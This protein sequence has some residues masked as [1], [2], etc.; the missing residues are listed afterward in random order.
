M[1]DLR[2]EF[3]SKFF[4]LK[5]NRKAVD[6]IF[7]EILLSKFNWRKS[8]NLEPPLK[9]GKVL[10]FLSFSNNVLKES[11]CLFKLIWNSN[12]SKTLTDITDY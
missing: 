6:L 7:W 10:V 8:S 4:S 2:Q 3:L 1:A 9:M 11:C 12:T 5:D